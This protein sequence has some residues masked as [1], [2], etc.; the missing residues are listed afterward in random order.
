MRTI[1]SYILVGAA[2]AM[3]GATFA[4]AHGNGADE[5]K[6]VESK[7]NMAMMGASGSTVDAVFARKMIAHHQGALDMARIEIASGSDTKLKQMAH[8]MIDDQSQGQSELQAW[9]KKH[10]G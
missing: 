5:F 9:L 6:V 2:C 1:Q 4:Y 8:K 10:G 7:M 3:L